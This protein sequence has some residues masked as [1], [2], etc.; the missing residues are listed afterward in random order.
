MA[1]SREELRKRVQSIKQSWLDEDFEEQVD[2]ILDSG[3]VDFENSEQNYKPAYPIVAA[4]LER[5]A[6]HCIYGGSYEDV[7][8]RQNRLKNK[9]KQLL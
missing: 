2:R 9:Y 3:A 1:I 5:C 4:I 6:Y 7:N 8:R